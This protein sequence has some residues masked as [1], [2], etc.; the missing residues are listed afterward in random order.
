MIE[1]THNT[2]S[3]APDAVLRILHDYGMVFRKRRWSGQQS[4]LEKK[5]VSQNCKTK[6]DGCERVSS[7]FGRGGGSHGTHSSPGHI[8]PRRWQGKAAFRFPCLCSYGILK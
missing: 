4:L 1:T 6:S 8:V 7:V 2:M 3:V 5:D